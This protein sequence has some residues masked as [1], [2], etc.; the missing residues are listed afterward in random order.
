[1]RVDAPTGGWPRPWPLVVEIADA[2][3]A[4]SWV[5]VGGLMVQLH[6]RAAGIESVRPTVDVDTLIDVMAPGG[7]IHKVVGAL[8]RL[9]FKIQ[10]P[11]WGKGAPVHRLM[12]GDDIVDVLV[13]DHLPSGKKP[14]LLR[15]RVMEIDGGAQALMRRQP[16]AIEYNGR[17]VELVVPDLLGAL[18]LKGA[19]HTADNLTPERHLAD[20]ALLASLVTDHKAVR[21]RLAGS[22]RKRLVH[23]RGEL[24]DPLSEAWLV[25]PVDLQQRGQ[26][27]L[28]ILTD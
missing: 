5:L 14:R 8:Q 9:G 17:G 13:A 19:A 20:A 15:R 10:E 27:T 11:G 1:M 7:G 21:G 25:L 24:A 22:D 18:V 6:A 2:L 3:P 12:R 16:V 23:L 26:D 28:R 4:D